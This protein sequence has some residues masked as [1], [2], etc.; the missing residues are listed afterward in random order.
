MYRWT[1]ICKYVGE[2]Q[3]LLPTRTLQSSFGIQEKLFIVSKGKSTGTCF[4]QNTSWCLLLIVLSV[5]VRL[6]EQNL[7]VPVSF[8]EQ[9]KV[10]HLIL[11]GLAGFQVLVSPAPVPVI[12]LICVILVPILRWRYG[13]DHCREHGCLAAGAARDEGLHHHL[14]QDGCRGSSGA[15]PHPVGG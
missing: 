12:A 11:E 7:L 6:K 5:R 9:S 2:A 3:P 4:K 15:H 1:Q 13:P 14:W 10:L 8:R